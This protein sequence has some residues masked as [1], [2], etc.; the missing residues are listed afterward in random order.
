VKEKK[1]VRQCLCGGRLFSLVFSYK[2]RPDGET[3]FQAG[4]QPRA[5]RRRIIRCLL[6]GH[7]MSVHKLD[8]GN[9]YENEYVQATY[10]SDAAMRAAFE[11]I[12]SLNPSSSDNAGRLGRVLSFARNH[13]SSDRFDHQ[14]PTILDVGSGLCVFLHGMKLANWSCTALD[15]DPRAIRHADEVVGVK[16]V[17]SDFMSAPLEERFDVITFN[18]VLEHVEDPVAVLSK[19]HYYLLEDGFV[20]AEVPDGEAAAIDGPGREEF[21]IEHLHIFSAASLALLAL[22]AGY[23]VEAL[24]RLREPSGKYTLFA[25]LTKSSAP[26]QA[27]RELKP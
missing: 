25:F 2:T 12:V 23:R 8:L 17:C 10:G 13:F 4:A 18:K 14:T 5:Y 3:D 15:P 6:C 11:R 9:F 16:G 19:S 24:E 22:R 20:Y 1:A 26:Y 7:C 27:D 21:F